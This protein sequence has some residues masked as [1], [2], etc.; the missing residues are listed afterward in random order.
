MG[1]FF[2]IGSSRRK[3]IEVSGHTNGHVAYYFK[4][5]NVIFCGITY[6]LGCGRLLRVEQSFKAQLLELQSECSTFIGS[7]SIHLVH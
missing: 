1:D 4:E 5:E 7:M 6:S 2:E 3:V